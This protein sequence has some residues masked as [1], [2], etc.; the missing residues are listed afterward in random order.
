MKHLPLLLLPLA[1]AATTAFAQATQPAIPAVV[2]GQP[3][4]TSAN[5][6]HD[7]AIASDASGLATSANYSNRSGYVGQ[8]YDVTALTLAADPASVNERATT[9][10]GASA[11]LDDGT[12][13][14]PA[15]A[16]VKWAVV[17]GPVTVI[18]ADGTAT[19]GSVYQDTTA[20]IQGTYSGVSATL[21]VTILN[22]TDDDDGPYAG[23]GLPDDWQVANFGEGSTVA[24][25]TADPDGDGQ[26]NL[27]EYLASTNPNLATSVFTVRIEP[28]AGQ[29][30]HKAI[31]FGPVA[32]GRTYRVLSSTDLSAASWTDISGPRTGA[33][34]NLTFTDTAA[35]S[36]RK[37]YRVQISNP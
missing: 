13:L 1:T 35:T 12:H 22:I 37:F 8:L 23:D 33:S 34:G 27:L 14:L 9:E 32:T 3:H 28:V 30:T 10:L 20:T 26:N 5:Y 25:P 21:V 18:A 7:S 16:D 29:P 2:S 31:V 36:A 15:G 17:S 4:A 24:G 6:R 19:A 11:T